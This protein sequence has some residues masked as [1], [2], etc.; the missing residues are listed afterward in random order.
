V[1]TKFY[2]RFLNR[3]A[4]FD[5]DIEFADV[6]KIAVEE[7]ALNTTDGQYIFDFIDQKRHPRLAKRIITTRNRSIVVNHLKATLY[8]SFFKDIYEDATQYLQSLLEAVAK[9]GLNPERIIGEHKLSLEANKI[10]RAG[11][12]EEVVKMIS[13]SVFRALEEERNTKK[14][15]EKLNG[16]L[17]LGVSAEIIN[18]ALPYLELRHL[19]V[20]SDGKADQ[21]F[22]N[23]YPVFNS[24]VGRKIQVDFNILNNARTSI[25]ALIAEFDQKAIEAG[26][27]NRADLQP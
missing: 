22:C 14:L 6:I 15:L 10:L 5:A 11:S 4:H 27:I 17:N 7:G 26:I 13:I 24:E 1:K 21:K 12:W 3:A 20:H 25:L 23:D 2:V 9:N 18:A 16:K 8:S 19:L